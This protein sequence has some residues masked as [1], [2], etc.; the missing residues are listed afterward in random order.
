VQLLIGGTGDLGGR[1][2]LR[3]AR[4]GVRLRALVRPGKDTAPLRAVGVEVVEGDLRDPESVTRAVAGCEAVVSTATAMGR[5]MGGEALS[6]HDV[7]GRGMLHLVEAA[8]RAGAARFVFVSAAAIDHPIAA[9]S[10]LG[11][12][13]RAVEARLR[14]SRMREVV[15]RPDMFMEVWLSAPVGFDW[16]GSAITV[17][18]RGDAP[19]AYVATD[20]VAELTARLA[21]APDPPRQLEFGGPEAMTRNEAIA[22]FERAT[23]RRF[24]VR[25]VPRLALRAGSL[26]L[27]SLRPH[28]ASA[29][30][31]SL[32]A[33]QETT[34][35]R[36]DDLRSAGIDP[37]PVSAYV[38]RVTRGQG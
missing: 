2:A 21:L 38:Q 4:R 29:M 13:K 32:V 16:Q 33:D 5:A 14:A 18:G 3:L 17:F 15:V 31:L 26:A 35:R 19:A 27:S 8:E 24:R 12:A 10:P 37:L 30:A 6:V 11:A 7:D 25:R 20:D 36:A 34:P 23:G 28:L 22:S 1:V 9:G